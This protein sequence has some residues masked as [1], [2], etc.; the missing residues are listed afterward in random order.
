[1]AP[2]RVASCGE[3]RTPSVSQYDPVKGFTRVPYEAL[4]TQRCH[5]H[6]SWSEN[7]G[8]G[9]LRTTEATASS[10]DCKAAH[11]ALNTP[12]IEDLRCRSDDPDAKCGPG[13]SSNKLY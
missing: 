7:Q 1:M 5:H 6:C 2:L 13:E 4:D 12:F 11:G 8:R 9:F 10:K 3:G